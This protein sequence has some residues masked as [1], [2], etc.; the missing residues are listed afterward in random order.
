MGQ[1]KLHTVV[2]IFFLFSFLSTF[3]FSQ[4]ISFTEDFSTDPTLNGW[5]YSGVNPGQTPHNPPLFAWSSSEQRLNVNYNSS[6]EN[7]MFY[8]ELGVDINECSIFKFSFKLFLTNI[9]A[10]T[11]GF[12][13]FTFGLRNT[14]RDYFDRFG[15]DFSNPSDP[16]SCFDIV[17]WGYIPNPQSPGPYSFDPFI[18]PTICTSESDNFRNN[19]SPAT[20]TQ[21][22]MGVLYIITQTYEPAER[23]LYLE[24]T[25][26]G[27]PITTAD[28]TTPVSLYE[29]DIFYCNAIAVS[30]YY[31]RF[32]WNSTP[33]TI[34]QG[35]IDDISFEYYGLA[36]SKNWNLFE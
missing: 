17:E 8:K 31:N 11:D 19:W 1:K 23:K 16:Y 25:A 32:D 6:F 27:V 28:V 3:L 14:T 29:G 22:Q 20:I 4:I 9:E 36:S 5:S 18:F 33:D 30:N 2:L 13:Q 21:L 26:D 24:M 34:V 7:S 12:C 15:K 35:Y 10:E